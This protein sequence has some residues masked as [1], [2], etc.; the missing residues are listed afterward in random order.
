[1]SAQR[2]QQ[3]AIV[4]RLAELVALVAEGS[5]ALPIDVEGPDSIRRLGL[6]SVRLLAFLVAVEDAFGVAWDEDLAPA[7]VSDFGAMAG[8]LQTRLAPAGLDMD[9]T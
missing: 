6:T 3:A 5:I 2:E 7:V 4:A 8:H 9:G 1:M